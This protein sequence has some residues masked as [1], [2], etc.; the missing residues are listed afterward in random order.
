MT[1]AEDLAEL[2]SCVLGPP[3]DPDESALAA[4]ER[5]R[6]HIAQLEQG[7]SDVLA[8]SAGLEQYRE[9]CSA[10]SSIKSWLRA[11][12]VRFV[13]VMVDNG[14]WTLEAVQPRVPIEEC[15]AAPGIDVPSHEVL[16]TE[17]RFEIE[18]V[19]RPTLLG[20]WCA[21]KL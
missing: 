14:K 1:I 5:V 19:P 6:A 16:Y 3:D 9:T 17:T 10:W 21:S 7:R 12:E 18:T 2:H 15:D 4:L 8:L 11:D 20:R 13:V